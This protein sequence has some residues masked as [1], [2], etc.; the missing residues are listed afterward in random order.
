[1]L[2]ISSFCFSILLP[3]SLGYLTIESG[4]FVYNKEKVFLS[5]VNT[6]WVHYARDF[7]SGAYK[8]SKQQFEKWLTEVSA[9]G[10]NAVRVWVHI[11]GQWSPKFDAQGFATG[12]DVKSL[13][14]ELGE[15]LDL[16]ERLNIF[17]IPCLWN[18][19]VKPQQMLHLYA[20]EAKLDSYLE[21]V[22]KPL[23]T[24]LKNKKSLGAWEIVNEVEGSVKQNISDPNPCFDTKKLLN[25]GADWAKSDLTMKQ[26]LNFINRHIDAIKTADPKALVTS[27]SWNERS[28]LDV[29]SNCFNYYTDEC[30]KAAGGKPK[31]V[32][33]IEYGV[34]KNFYSHKVLL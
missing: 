17:V 14:E 2:L 27:G 12:E 30:L 9:A 15:F 24:G 18:G 10:G 33:G 21:K 22:L 26:A 28:N 4:H 7:G 1:M 20:D 25:S 6:P 5:G 16:A 23:V 29:C 31:G 3:I 8:S 13:I 34:C 11:D 32:L 19:A